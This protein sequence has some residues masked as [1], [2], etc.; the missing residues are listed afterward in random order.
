MD[1]NLISRSALLEEL[2]KINP[3]EKDH[4]LYFLWRHSLS[5]A[6]RAIKAAPAVDAVEVVRCEK[7]WHRDPED[8][9]CKHHMNNNYF[10]R[11]DDGFCSYGER[12]T[13]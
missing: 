1:N 2:S 5:V 3:I 6:L 13:E 8:K 7:C 12:R 11:D 10:A 4:L 9:R